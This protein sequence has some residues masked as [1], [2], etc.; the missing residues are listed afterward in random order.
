MYKN[1]IIIL[2]VAFSLNTFAQFGG[3]IER[4]Y[5]KKVENN[6]KKEGEKEAQKGLDAAYNEADRGLDAAEAEEQRFN[7]WAEEEFADEVVYIDENLIDASQI[8]WQRLKFASGQDLIFYDK[9]FNYE[10]DN[11]APSNWIIQYRSSTQIADFD[12]GRMIVA[13]GEGFLTPKMTNVKEDYLPDNFTI[14][15][16]FM[17]PVVP[18]SKPM[19]IHFFA[20]NQQSKKGFWPIEINK[21]LVTYK[22]ST[23]KYP[24]VFVDDN[25]MD[26]WYRCSIS[27]DKG[28]IKVYLNERLM[29]TYEDDINPTGFSLDYMA[30]TPIFFKNFIIATHTKSIEDQLNEGEYVSYNV[31]YVS[32]KELLS[33]RS[34]SELAPIANMLNADPDMEIEVDVYFSQQE[35]EKDNKKFGQKKAEDIV[36]ALVSMGASEDQ[37]K[38]Q[39]KGSIESSKDNTDNHKSEMVVFK[40][41]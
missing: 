39:Y 4:H 14:E 40:K 31:D 24:I 17:M 21:N 6:F 18:F 38:S 36:L 35:K 9:P 25:G 37:I 3:S 2:L 10:K 32:Y 13:G 22:D 19:K 5:R 29:I 8:Q 15:F 34:I 33:G 7:D 20:K 30:Y 28:L 23:A 11:K 26:Q 16:D 1:L 27:F 12:Q 41:K